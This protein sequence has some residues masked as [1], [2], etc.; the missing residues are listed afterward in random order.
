[1]VGSFVVSASAD[2]FSP[3]AAHSWPGLVEL[4]AIAVHER[5]SGLTPRR[6]PSETDGNV[7]V[8]RVVCEIR[9]PDHNAVV[10]FHAPSFGFGSLTVNLTYTG[11]SVSPSDGTLTMQT[12]WKRPRRIEN[13]M[14]SAPTLFSFRRPVTTIW[15]SMFMT[16][17]PSLSLGSSGLNRPPICT[18]AD[19]DF[20]VVGCGCQTYDLLTRPALSEAPCRDDEWPWKSGAWPTSWRSRSW[21]KCRD[22]RLGRR[23]KPPRCSD[24]GSK[25]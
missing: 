23:S 4:T 17:V 25:R 12:S 19:G 2:H 6:A 16:V 18:L 22:D 13:V 14:I 1:M 7:V 15:G 8:L 9:D 20:P 5:S 10:H 3:S 21:S 11:A 24:H